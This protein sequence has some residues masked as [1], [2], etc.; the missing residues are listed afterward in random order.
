MDQTIKNSY[1][2]I[3]DWHI[4]IF[5]IKTLYNIEALSNKNTDITDQN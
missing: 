4:K 5:H 2:H 3:Q 1:K